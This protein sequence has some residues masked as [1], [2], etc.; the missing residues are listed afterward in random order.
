MRSSF[1]ERMTLKLL[2]P[3]SELAVFCIQ[4]PPALLCIPFV[5][6]CVPPVVVVVVVD[7]RSSIESGEARLL[8]PPLLVPQLLLALPLLCGGVG[9]ARVGVALL[10]VRRPAGRLR[11]VAGAGD[12]RTVV[13]GGGDITDEA[14]AALTVPLD[15]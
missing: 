12:M 9:V 4:S 14:A 8:P 11:S 15:E 10:G 3:H 5:D 1:T 6:I 7:G 2:T 13:V